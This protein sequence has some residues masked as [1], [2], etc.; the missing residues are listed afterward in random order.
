MLE[1]PV[2]DRAPRRGG[3]GEPIRS[4]VGKVDDERAGLEL[5]SPARGHEHLKAGGIVR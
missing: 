5:S 4:R 2:S 3:E 1:I